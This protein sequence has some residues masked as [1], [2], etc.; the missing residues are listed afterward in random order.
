V[1]VTSG[2]VIM[3]AGKTGIIVAM[4]AAPG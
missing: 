4:H 3:I 2:I 1:I